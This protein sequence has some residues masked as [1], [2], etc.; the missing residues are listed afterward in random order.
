MLQWYWNAPPPV[1]QT[2]EGCV[3]FTLG[4]GSSEPVP[5]PSSSVAATLVPTTLATS[6]LASSSVPAVSMVAVTTSTSMVNVPAPTASKSATVALPVVPIASKS[7]I[8]PAPPVTT[9]SADPVT[10]LPDDVTLTDLLQ[11][12]E[13]ALEE[14]EA[15][16]PV[17]RS[18][19][20][21]PRTG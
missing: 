19:A 14:V 16:K 18:R 5:V 10:S 2:Y 8:A 13:I 9:G 17:Q 4:G 20:T 7:V 21:A 11:W 6:V 3:D 15:G 1:N 12:L